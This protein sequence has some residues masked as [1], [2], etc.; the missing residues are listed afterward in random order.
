MKVWQR[1]N[2][3]EK[4]KDDCFFLCCEGGNQVLSSLFTS[5]QNMFVSLISPR[6]PGQCYCYS[7]HPGRRIIYLLQFFSETSTF[8]LFFP[9][10][11]GAIITTH[12]THLDWLIRCGFQTHFI[13]AHHY[14]GTVRVPMQLPSISFSCEGSGDTVLASEMQRKLI[15]SCWC[16]QFPCLLP[17]WNMSCRV[18]IL[19][20]WRLKSYFRVARQKGVGRLGNWSHGGALR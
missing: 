15:P 8:L 13:P 3:Q 10:L 1:P 5:Q 7:L 11:K 16:L 14:H 17:T 20:M 19:Q 9:P 6:P 18:A 2:W 4:L 12:S